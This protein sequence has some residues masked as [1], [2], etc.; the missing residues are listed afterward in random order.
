MIK[1]KAIEVNGV[2]SPETLPDTQFGNH[3]D[4][5]N[6]YFFESIEEQKEF[7]LILET[8]EFYTK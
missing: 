7:Y 8:Q 6:F 2:L 3:C 5:D 1:I 4:G